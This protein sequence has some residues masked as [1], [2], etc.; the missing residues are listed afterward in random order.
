[1]RAVRVVSRGGVTSRG[2]VVGSLTNIASGNGAVSISPL[3]G[4]T[5][6][7]SEPIHLRLCERAGPRPTTELDAMNV[8]R[9]SACRLPCL[10]P[11]KTACAAS[12]AGR[13]AAGCPLPKLERTRVLPVRG[14]LRRFFWTL[15]FRVES[16]STQ[17]GSSADAAFS[18]I[19]L[20]STRPLDL[21]VQK[22]RIVPCTD[23]GR[24]ALFRSQSSLMP[25]ARITPPSF[26]VSDLMI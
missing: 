14:P 2:S 7:V 6:R 25:A 1:M 15:R 12:R 18:P 24:N 26:T 8:R 20:A 9:A 10:S 19:E 16:G 17:C 22:R 4:T 11:R 21:Q 13:P 5:P 3:G 23:R